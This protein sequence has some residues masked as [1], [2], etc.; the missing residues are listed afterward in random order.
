[1]ILTSWVNFANDKKPSAAA[2][3]AFH[4]GGKQFNSNVKCFNC[5]KTGHRK[6]ECKERLAPT[7]TRECF[8]CGRP[9]HM[10][11]DCR[12]APK[13]K[14]DNCKKSNHATSECWAD[15]GAAQRNRGSGTA[16]YSKQHGAEDEDYAFCFMAASHQLPMTACELLVDSGCT[17]YMLRDRE[18]FC[19]LDETRRGKVG[20]ANSSQ[21][22]I[23]GT[24]TAQFWVKDDRGKLRRMMLKD[25]YYVPSYSRNLV[26]VKRL[27]DSGATVNFG[28]SPHILSPEGT[29]FPFS[30]S[31][32]LF[33]LEI[34]RKTTE[35]AMQSHSI[36]RWHERLGHNN[37]QDVGRLERAVEGMQVTP[38]DNN[39]DVCVPCAKQKAK[40][41][42]TPKTWGTRATDP[43]DIVHM[44]ILGP[45]HVE[46]VDGYRY[47]VGFIDSYS[48]YATVYLVKTKDECFAKLQLY[49]ADVGCLES[50]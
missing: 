11:R 15:G 36:T 4:S 47:A 40:R 29:V 37:K 7:N 44:D 42:P 2:S 21:S 18:L 35:T 20:N 1:V 9:G 3:S 45:L 43:M 48:R 28:Q 27:N 32:N 30:V 41:A 34:F 16:N 14:C 13:K 33:T 10:A 5:K 19:D 23:E 24:G 12:S 31:S 26:S 50:S 17:G 49:V 39:K 46:S 22:Q 6:S 38:G 8:N 25:A